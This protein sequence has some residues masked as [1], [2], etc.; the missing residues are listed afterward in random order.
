MGMLSAGSIWV[1]GIAGT[2]CIVFLHEGL[3]AIALR[4]LAKAL[5]SGYQEQQLPGLEPGAFARFFLPF[6]AFVLG[7]SIWMGGLGFYTGVRAVI[8]EKKATLSRDLDLRHY[9]GT[10][11]IGIDGTLTSDDESVR[12]QVSSP[13]MHELERQLAKLKEGAIVSFYDN[14]AEL[15]V[16]AQKGLNGIRLKTTPVGWNDLRALDSFWLWLGVFIAGGI[17]STAIIGASFSSILRRSMESLR[18][19]IRAVARGEAPAAEGIESDDPISRMSWGLT[20]VFRRLY[21]LLDSNSQ[22]VQLTARGARELSSEARKLDRLAEQQSQRLRNSTEQVRGVLEGVR[23]ISSSATEQSRIVDRMVAHL[24]ELKQSTDAFLQVAEHYRAQ[25]VESETQAGRA[26]EAAQ[27]GI[28]QIRL[29]I[30][31]AQHVLESARVINDI[32]QRTNLLSLNAAI[33]ASRAGEF[34]QGF[35]VVADEISRLADA[36]NQAART[37]EEKTRQTSARM[38]GSLAELEMVARSISELATMAHTARSQ[39]DEITERVQ[40]NGEVIGETRS[41]S[42]ELASISRRMVEIQSSQMEQVDEV[43]RD[44]DGIEALTS[45]C[46]QLATIMSD[47][48]HALTDQ[49]DSVKE[50]SSNFQQSMLQTD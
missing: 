6:V 21:L 49:M 37:I 11:I 43:R 19:V 41:R 22:A 35:A 32:A 26:S 42:R 8:A 50:K 28:S 38:E 23:S 20:G 4:P 36:S 3:Q 5:T 15:V 14:R 31:D 47:Q 27:K 44:L 17:I 7:Y 18:T 33:E 13:G 24:S 48:L 34:G 30:R 10:R 39:S 12:S 29:L 9:S 45:D 1:G 25:S 40:A 2:V 16:A 46:S